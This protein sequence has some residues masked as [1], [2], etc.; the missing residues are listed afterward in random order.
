MSGIVHPHFLR[1][2]TP[3]NPNTDRIFIMNHLLFGI[4]YSSPTSIKYPELLA[5][6]HGYR[7][8]SEGF[9]LHSM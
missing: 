5:I 1:L 3:A 6:I 9:C 2:L 7:Y 8:L 4:R